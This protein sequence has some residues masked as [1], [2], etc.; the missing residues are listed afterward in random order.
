MADPFMIGVWIKLD[1]D[2]PPRRAVYTLEQARNVIDYASGHPKF[3]DWGFYDP[4]EEE[5]PAPDLKFSGKDHRRSQ[6]VPPSDL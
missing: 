4:R 6:R 3:Q 1:D 2:L 5:V